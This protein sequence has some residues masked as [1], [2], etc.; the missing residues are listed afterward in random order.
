MSFRGYEP[1]THG[2]EIRL[3]ILYA[4][5]TNAIT[6]K[7]NLYTVYAKNIIVSL[8]TSLTYVVS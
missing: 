8:V 2:F 3:Q 1:A 4:M 6:D 7:N 5:E